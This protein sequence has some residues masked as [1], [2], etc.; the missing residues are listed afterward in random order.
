MSGI[1]TELLA[2]VGTIFLEG[3]YVVYATMLKNLQT[4]LHV[5]SETLKYFEHITSQVVLIPALSAGTLLLIWTSLDERKKHDGERLTENPIAILADIARILTPITIYSQFLHIFSKSL[6]PDQLT[7]N[8]AYFILFA[9]AAYQI[10]VNTIHRYKSEA[11]KIPGSNIDVGAAAHETQ[12]AKLE[13]E[14]EDVQTELESMFSLDEDQDGVPDISQA[15]HI[16]T[17]KRYD[18]LRLREKELLAQLPG[19]RTALVD[20]H[21]A[22]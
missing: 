20:Y 7:N 16:A 11:R 10:A 2:A 1:K 5:S 8:S 18:T 6:S 17:I 15:T 13:K 14:L 21:N 4:P 3:G 19:A 9:A 22:K 12:I